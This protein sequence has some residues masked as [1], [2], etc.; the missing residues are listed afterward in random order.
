MTNR[1]R[2][3]SSAAAEFEAIE[4]ASDVIYMIIV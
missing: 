1:S 2:N 3:Q 4:L